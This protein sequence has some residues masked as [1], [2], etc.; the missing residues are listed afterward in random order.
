MSEEGLE[1]PDGR[2]AAFPEALSGPC[3]LLYATPGVGGLGMR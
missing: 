3:L 2:A 1:E